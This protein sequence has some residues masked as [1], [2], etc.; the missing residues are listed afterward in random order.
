MSCFSLLRLRR[1]DLSFC[2]WWM[3]E[4]VQTDSHDLTDYEREGEV[5][6]DFSP[7]LLVSV[8]VPV[9]MYV[10]GDS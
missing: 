6:S 5:E 2:L 8:T 4:L 9:D 10:F 7:L 1:L 3:T